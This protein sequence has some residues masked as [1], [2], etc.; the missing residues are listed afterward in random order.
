MMLSHA[1]IFSWKPNGVMK[2]PVSSIVVGIRAP[3]NAYD[4]QIL[5]V[6]PC[7]GIYHREAPNGESNNTGSHSSGA[8]IAISNIADIELVTASHQIEVGLCNEMVQQG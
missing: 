2:N 6:S 3:N 8:G 5:T 1:C 7:N 4:R